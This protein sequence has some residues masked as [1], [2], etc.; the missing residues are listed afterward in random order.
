M[1]I[2]IR[3]RFGKDID[4]ISNKKLLQKIIKIINEIEKSDDI[5]EI[6]NI[7]KMKGKTFN[8]YRIKIGDYRIGIFYVDGMIELTRFMHRKDIYRYFPI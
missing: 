2:K 5:L 1:K 7:K 8:A 6:S 4:K 3:K